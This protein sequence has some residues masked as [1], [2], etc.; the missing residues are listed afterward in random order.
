[1]YRQIDTLYRVAPVRESSAGEKNDIGTRIGEDTAGVTKRIAC[2]NG[3][4]V[5]GIRAV[6]IG[7]FEMMESTI[8]YDVVAAA[9]ANDGIVE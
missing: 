9:I 2:A 5:D 6:V 8:V 4:E 3:V 1:M 7:E